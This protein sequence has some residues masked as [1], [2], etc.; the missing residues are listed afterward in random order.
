MTSR[1]ELKESQYLI[2]LLYRIRNYKPSAYL[3]IDEQLV[4]VIGRCPFRTY[5]PNKPD[6]YGIKIDRFVMLQ[7]N[8]FSMQ[9]PILENQLTLMEL[10]W[11]T[12]EN[13]NVL[14]LSTMHTS[15]VLNPE[16]SK[17]ELIQLYN[18]TKGAVDT[19]DQMSRNICCNKR[20]GAGLFASYIIC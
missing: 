16:T 11:L 4:D 10:L 5:M 19:F 2:S 18:S 6:K 20:L 14:L 13:K 12:K 17:P 9:A 7:P 8:R 3:C 15:N 1:Q